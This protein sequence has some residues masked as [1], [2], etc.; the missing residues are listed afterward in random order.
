M[1]RSLLISLFL[2][3]FIKPKAQDKSVDSALTVLTKSKEDTNKVKTLVWLGYHY[4]W[5][6]PKKTIKYGLAA[7]SLAQKLDYKDGEIR[8]YGTLGE[9]MAVMGNFEKATE[10]KFKMLQLAEKQGNS[11][12]ITN[13]YITISGGYFYQGQYEECIRYAK[14]ALTAPGNKDGVWA[15]GLYGFQGEAF[16]KL[17]QLDSALFYIQK[18][19]ELDLVSEKHWS[20][21]Y[22]YLG[23]IYSKKGDHQRAVEYYKKGLSFNPPNLDV[24]L[25]H[26]GLAGVFHLMGRN[27]SA[28][29]YVHKTIT[30]G[31]AYSFQAEVT[32]AAA[33]AK[34]IF[35]QMGRIDSAFHYQEMMIAAKDS[36]FSQEKMKAV[37]NLMFN[38]QLREQ[39]M[40]FQKMKDAKERKHNLQYAGIAIGLLGFL[41]LF[42]LFSHSAFAN[43]QL[44]RFL[45]IIVLLVVFEFINLLIHPYLAHVTDHSPLWMLLIMVCIAALLVPIHHY[46][47]KWVSHQLVEKNKKIRLRAAKETIA[48]LEEVRS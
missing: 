1:Y 36:L 39:E 28:L 6:D 11:K 27:D 10:L 9:A 41:I 44:I 25:G 35:K 38:E 37:Q 31:R 45:G 2:L 22:Y 40:A 42:L 48:K 13:A 5:R 32:D 8:S 12:N 20:I 14:K 26:L 19:Y 16:F 47:E 34:T 23:A 30:D 43:Q 24:V 46:L 29:F 7:L 3:C 4:Q 15:E 21:P 18:A 33:L 17:N